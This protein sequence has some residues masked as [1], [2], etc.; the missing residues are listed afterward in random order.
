MDLSLINL[1][2]EK[3]KEFEIKE[4]MNIDHHMSCLITKSIRINVFSIDMYIYN[5]GILI[6]YISRKEFMNTKSEDLCG[7]LKRT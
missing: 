4:L 5:N 6:L 2:K 3:L 7:K 1:I